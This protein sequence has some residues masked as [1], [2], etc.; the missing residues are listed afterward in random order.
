QNIFDFGRGHL[1]VVV[2]IQ[3]AV[4]A[5]LVAT[6]SDVQMHADRNAQAQGLLVHLC[7]KAHCASGGEAGKFVMGW[8]DTMRMPCWE[9]SFTNC[10]A[11]RPAWSG[12]TSNSGQILLVTISDNGVRPSAACQ[13]SVATSLSVKKVESTADIIIISPPM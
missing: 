1:A 12:S 9:R 8:S 5:T 2:V 4:D 3:I 11:S 10:S 6:V 13:I 7:Q